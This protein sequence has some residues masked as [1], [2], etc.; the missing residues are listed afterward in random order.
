MVEVAPLV[1]QYL[2]EVRDYDPVAPSRSGLTAYDAQLGHLGRDRAQQTIKRRQAIQSALA[3]ADD[4]AL[5]QRDR[6]DRAFTIA[7]IGADLVELG[8]EPWSTRPDRSLGHV[9]QGIFALLSRPQLDGA[10]RWPALVARLQQA[11]AV[12]DTATNELDNRASA[13][14]CELASHAAVAGG[15][16]LGQLPEIAR[17][18]RPEL[19]ADVVTAATAAQASLVRFQQRLAEVQATATGTT[20]TGPEQYD[21]LLGQYQRMPHDHRSLHVFGE[22]MIVFFEQELAACAREIDPDRAWF[23]I[24]PAL[25]NDY[26]AAVEVIPAYRH[27]IVRSRAFVEEKDLATIPAAPDEQFE[28][29]ETPPFMRSTIPFGFVSMAPV[30]ATNGRSIWSITL[31][32]EDSSADRNVQTLQGH[33]RWN[34]WAITFHEGYPGHHL[35]A[36]HL[37]EVESDVRRQ[38]TASIFIEGWG[39]YTEELMYVQ[40]YLSDPRVRLM[41]LVNGLWRAVRVV[42]DS[43]IHTRGMTISEAADMLVNVSR[44]EPTNALV[45]AARYAITPT[46]AA[47]Y[48]VGR[49]LVLDLRRRSFAQNPD[50]TLKLFHDQ[51]LSYGA[52][53]LDLVEAEMLG[54]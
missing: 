45:E 52:I 9:A 3:A 24:V 27:E 13:H 43:G 23:E 21:V 14:A 19:A 11:S 16:F 41:Q 49:G 48:L 35:H 51:L 33:N 22:E 50:Q 54:P 37:K 17:S 32:T 28:V 12:Y 2:S 18:Q 47:S 42:V 20:A 36:L 15:R 31:P 40:G 26:V 4:S 44:L 53:P 1:E 6:L 10:D 25:K 30:Y 5:N 38:F 8:T 7:M 39:L 29:G 34:T 46:Y